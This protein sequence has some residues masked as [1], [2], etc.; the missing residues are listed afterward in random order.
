MILISGATGKTGRWVVEYFLAAGIP[1]RAIVRDPA[2]AAA[3]SRLGLD[4][5]TGDLRD[6]SILTQAMHGIERAMLAT[7]NAPEQLEIETGF[8]DAAA[9]AGVSHIVKL[10]AIGADAHSS[11]VLKRYHGEAEAHLRRSGLTYTVLQPNFYMDNLLALAPGIARDNAL[12]L[13]MGVGRVG[14]IDVRDVA[15]VLFAALTQPGQENQTSVLTGPELLSFGDMAT[16]IS[17]ELGREICYVDQ[18]VTEFRQAML[19]FGVPAWNVDAM[20]DL[21]ALIR[22]DR[23]ACLTDSYTVISGRAPR[24]LRAFV[25]DHRD[26][27]TPSGAAPAA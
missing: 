8:I 2:K 14:A 1:V 15:A 9:T 17:E 19:G 11:A 6:R 24:T 3:M 27:F 12:A 26:R 5:I 4:V 23:N 21:F 18:P 20:L 10:S 13:P 16:V 7:A 25:R 22:E